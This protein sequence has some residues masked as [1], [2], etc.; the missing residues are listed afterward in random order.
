MQQQAEEMR[1]NQETKQ[2]KLAL[3]AMERQRKMP[4][5]MEHRGVEETS[6]AAVGGGKAGLRRVVGGRKKKVE[7]E[8]EVESESEEE[9]EGGAKHM[10][11]MMYDH[12]AKVHGEG[13]ARRFMKGGFGV[14]S[15]PPQGQQVS[16]AKMERVRLP[17]APATGA[18][19][20]PGAIAPRAY[21]GAPQAP[22]S[23]QRNSVDIGAPGLLPSAIA[24]T[25]KPKRTNARGQMISHLMKTK[26]MTLPEA[27]RWLKEHPQ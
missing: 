20:A 4:Q 1:E 3:R 15:A 23:F 21:G 13:Y 6:P 2:N 9:M 27:S 16:H 5:L 25:G 24:G 17:G 22:A 8:C 7:V 26:G 14:S 18:T 19:L 11:R 10:G 12:L